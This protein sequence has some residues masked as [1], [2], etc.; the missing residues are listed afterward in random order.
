MKNTKTKITHEVSKS[1]YINKND[2]VSSILDEVSDVKNNKVKNKHIINKL[3]NISIDVLKEL[4][5]RKID[6]I[7]MYKFN[8]YMNKTY[9][10]LEN[11]TIKIEFS[12]FYY[13]YNKS[14]YKDTYNVQEINDIKYIIV[15]K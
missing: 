15:N 10:K 9:N 14:R 2:L 6:K 13:L 1:E 7:E 8:E 5:N 3:Y 4:N 12:T 11:K